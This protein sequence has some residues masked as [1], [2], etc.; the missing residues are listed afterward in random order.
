MVKEIAM[1]K[2]FS[3]LKIRGIELK[4]RIAMSPM[5]Q[6]SCADGMVSD[7]HLVH[8][9][10]RAIGGAALI[11]TEATAIAP[12][13]RI[14]PD[15][16]GIWN[17]AQA[18]A[19]KKITAFISSTRAV[20]GIQLAHA[21]RKASTYAPGKGDG[22][23]KPENGGWL[24][25]APSQIKFSENFPQPKEMTHSDIQ[26]VVEQFRKAA[27]RSVRAGFQIIE[28]HMAHGYLLHEFLSPFSNKRN[29]EYGGSFENRIRLPLEVLTAV[30]TVVPDS[31]PVFARI[32]STE[33]TEGGWDIEQSVELARKLKEAGADLIDTS[34][35][36]NIPRASIP[37][38]PGYQIPLAEKIKRESGIMTGAVGF[39]TSPEQAEQIIATGQA[40]IVLL[41]RELLRNPYWPLTA[42]RRL[43]A[44][45][46][47]P[48]QYLRA[49]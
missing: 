37:I 10:S 39:I 30:R 22:E 44:D 31:F 33:W 23:V 11:L 17:D 24:T 36:G 25:L 3:P 15:D 7:W 47:W 48:R 28:L 27:E 34:S 38:G 2:L 14:S 19:F 26:S 8:Y 49:K 13:G 21:G 6:Y 12:E 40:D 29:D 20:P 35:G 32:S 45:I 41:A 43:K 18:D 4:N 42:A 9:G 5:C 46:D 1:S 16:A